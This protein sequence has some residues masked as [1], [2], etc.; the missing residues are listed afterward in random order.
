[1]ECAAFVHGENAMAKTILHFHVQQYMHPYLVHDSTTRSTPWSNGLNR[2][3]VSQVLS[4]TT[5]QFGARLACEQI[6]G[7]G[8]AF[9]HSNR[10]SNRFSRDL[11]SIYK[12]YTVVKLFGRVLGYGVYTT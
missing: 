8:C 6:V 10:H 7:C 1:M 11:Y 4:H 12:L 3:A 5:V 9:S 2:A